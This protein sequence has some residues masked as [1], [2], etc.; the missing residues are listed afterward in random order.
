MPGRKPQAQDHQHRG[1]LAPVGGS[2]ALNPDQRQIWKA[3]VE[4]SWP[5]LLQLTGGQTYLPVPIPE[6]R[7][8]GF[9]EDKQ[10]WVYVSEYN[11][12]IAEGSFCLSRRTAPR[13]AFSERSLKDILRAFKPTLAS[14]TGRI[15]RR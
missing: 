7:C 11:Y 12:D 2:G 9:D 13:K 6:R 15:A 8:A 10:L 1:D 5:F 3:G 14:R 4:T